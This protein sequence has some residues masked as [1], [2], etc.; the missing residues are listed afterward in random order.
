MT[1]YN[2]LKAKD[3]GVC[4]VC[5]KFLHT[6]L[7][8]RSFVEVVMSPAVGSWFTSSAPP[9]HKLAYYWVA[10]S[11]LVCHVSSVGKRHPVV[12]LFMKITRNEKN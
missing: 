9:I 7:P 3:K 11:C 6:A 5:N 1:E 8:S 10:R 12:E 2:H 4:R